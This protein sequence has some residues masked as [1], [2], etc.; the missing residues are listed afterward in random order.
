ARSIQSGTQGR[1]GRLAPERG[2]VGLRPQYGAAALSVLRLG[3]DP[4]GLLAHPLG[5]KPMLGDEKVHLCAL[6]PDPL[7]LVPEPVPSLALPLVVAAA[8]A[9]AALGS[10]KLRLRLLAARLGVRLAALLEHL[11]RRAEPVPDLRDLEAL[12]FEVG[13]GSVRAILQICRLEEHARRGVVQLPGAVEGVDRRLLAK[14]GSKLGE[15]RLVQELRLLLLRCF[16]LAAALLDFRPQALHFGLTEQ[17]KN[18]VQALGL[19]PLLWL[20]RRERRGRGRPP[21]RCPRA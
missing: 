17:G 9:V 18:F 13:N 20:T 15:R 11:F 16:Q 6:R 5:A 2:R 21:P 19:H 10:A 12:L 7:H 14:L 4:L 8:G 3:E 1:L